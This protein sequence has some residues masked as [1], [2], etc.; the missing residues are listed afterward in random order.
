MHFS[1][2]FTKNISHGIF[3]FLTYIR[4]LQSWKT[5][6]A[7]QSNLKIS[8]EI[9]S[10]SLTLTHFNIHRFYLFSRI[11]SIITGLLRAFSKLIRIVFI[12]GIIYKLLMFHLFV[13]ICN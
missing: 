5:W 3:C 10:T 13:K 12:I 8:L 4:F 11:L 1:Y 7:I 2:N 6:R 9:K